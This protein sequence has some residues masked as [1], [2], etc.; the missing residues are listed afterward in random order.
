MNFDQNAVKIYID[1]STP[2]NPGHKGGIAG[3]VEYPDILN[4]KPEVIFKKVFSKTT[5]NRME[6]IAC[7]KAF[8][9]ISKK[10]ELCGNRAIIISDSKYLCDNK[11]R[12]IYWRTANWRNNN[13]RAVENPDLWKKLL[14]LRQR[15]RIRVDIEWQKGKSSSLLKE[16]DRVAKMAVG[17]LTDSPDFGYHPG[18]VFCTKVLSGIPTLFPADGQEVNIRVYRKEFKKTASKKEYKIIF[19]L[20][21]EEKNSYTAKHFAYASPA[22]ERKLNR[23]H[24]YHVQFNENPKYPIIKRIIKKLQ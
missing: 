7:L 20:F 18:K 8:E 17:S 3:I 1:G 14:S 5:N 12:A 4:R 15:I 11:N 6:L 21:S 24:R 19:D 13:G 2:N 22:I 16:V 9:W 10:I 23:S